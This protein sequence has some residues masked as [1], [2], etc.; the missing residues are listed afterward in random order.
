MLW[1]R[2]ASTDP[3]RK[4]TIAAWKKILRPYRSPSLPHSGVDAVDASRYAVTT[5]ERCCRP[6]RS[7]TMVGRAIETMVWSSAARSMPR[8]RAPRMSQRRRPTTSGCVPGCCSDWTAVCSAMTPPGR[9]GMCRLPGWTGLGRAARSAASEDDDLRTRR[10]DRRA[11]PVAGPALHD[12]ARLGEQAAQVLGVDEPQRAAEPPLVPRAQGAHDMGDVDEVPVVLD[13]VVEPRRERLA[14]GRDDP[15]AGERRHPRRPG[16]R[17]GVAGLEG[18]QPAGFEVAVEGA[19]RRADGVVV[20]EQL[21]RMA[22]HRHQREAL[23][24]V[25]RPCVATDPRDRRTAGPRHREHRLGRVD[26]DQTAG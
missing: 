10:E 18:E 4:I 11:V 17:S 23:A 19:Q 7:A 5:Q 15:D 14:V 1:L 24:E 20:Q 12:E 25:E 8:S 16:A 6:P 2:P 26:A 3:I 9:D 22:R 21:E 13:R